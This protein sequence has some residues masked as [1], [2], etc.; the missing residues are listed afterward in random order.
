MIWQSLYKQ[1]FRVQ[2]ML[3]TSIMSER[4]TEKVLAGNAHTLVKYEE[5]TGIFNSS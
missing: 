3:R 4:H 5:Q 2:L 1:A